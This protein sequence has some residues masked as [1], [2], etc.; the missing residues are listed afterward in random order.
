MVLVN[1]CATFV[2]L[3]DDTHASRQQKSPTNPNAYT[4]HILQQMSIRNASSINLLNVV[5]TNRKASIAALEAWN[6][7]VRRKVSQQSS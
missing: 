4:T 6:G 7:V 3:Q 1:G 5:H 2:V